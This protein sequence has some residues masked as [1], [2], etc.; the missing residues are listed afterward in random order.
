MRAVA[1]TSMPLSVFPCLVYRLRS[2][3]LALSQ[4]DLVSPLGD[5]DGV[6]VAAG[7]DA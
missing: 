4:Q 1:V 2:P 6:D 7:L 5:V 3:L